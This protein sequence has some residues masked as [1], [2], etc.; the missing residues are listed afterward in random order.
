MTHV[1][2]R[3]DKMR[4]LSKRVLLRQDFMNKRSHHLVP[5]SKVDEVIKKSNRFD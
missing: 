5:Y 3:L 4:V 2:C 1:T